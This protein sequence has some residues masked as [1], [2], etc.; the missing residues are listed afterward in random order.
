ML[1]PETQTIREMSCGQNLAYILK[2][3]TVFFATEYKVLQSRQEGCFVRCMK[4]SWN[5]QQMLLYRT[6]QFKSLSSLLPSLSAETFMSVGSNLLS[7][8]SDVMDNGFLTCSNIDIHPEHIYIEPSTYKVKLIYVPSKEKLYFDDITFEGELRSGLIKIIQENPNLA[9]A[10]TDQL[11]ANLSNGKI[12]FKDLLSAKTVSYGLGP[13]QGAAANGPLFGT[14]ALS[15]RLIAL[16]A[17]YKFE[18]DVNKESF[19]V[20]KKPETCDGI[21]VYNRMISRTHCVIEKTSSGF[22]V[23]D[24][25][26]ANGT[27]I[28]GL[29]I[30]PGYSYNLNN[31][32]ILRL[33]DSDF[34][35]VTL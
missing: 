19:V 15:M 4:M 2:D 17:P 13:D 1:S 8:I 9:C 25:K 28:N 31:G 30:E 6:D 16:N 5:G 7:D 34:Q 11:K 12:K 35:V 29:R 18:L 3:E 33:A 10:K 24:L 26:S 14:S 20:G 27:Y 32:D 23:T 21:I 22:T